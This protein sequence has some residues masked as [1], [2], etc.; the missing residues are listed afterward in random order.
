M[1]FMLIIVTFTFI[2]WSILWI[3]FQWLICVIKFD[4]NAAIRSNSIYCKNVCIFASVE[5]FGEQHSM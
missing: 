1:L 2:C 4:L 5:V 3:V